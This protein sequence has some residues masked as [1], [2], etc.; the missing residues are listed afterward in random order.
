MTDLP[1]TDPRPVRSG[2]AGLLALLWLLAAALM[3]VSSPALI[4]LYDEALILT[5]ALRILAGETPGADFYVNYGPAQ[6]YA[7]AGVYRLFGT[8]MDAVRVYDAIV[9]GAVAPAVWWTL[10][11]MLPPEAPWRWA[12]CAATA[13]LATAMMIATRS[14]LYPLI[15]VTVLLVW[16]A[17][18]TARALEG[19][20]RPARYLPVIAVIGLASLVRYDFG[21]LASAAFAVPIALVHGLRWRGGRES[22]AVIGALAWRLASAYAVML[23]IVL[24]V[25]HA[26]G[27]LVPALADLAML[28]DGTYARTRA[29]PFPPV[30]F[31]ATAPVEASAIYLPFA[32]AIA[33]A[34]TLALIWRT[35]AAP[36]AGSG[37]VHAAHGAVTENLTENLTV[38]KTRPGTLP[39][40][41]RTGLLILLAVTLVGISKGMIRVSGI[42]FMAGSVPA[43]PLLALCLFAATRRREGAAGAPRRRNPVLAGAGLALAAALT[44]WT[45]AERFTG[46]A[47]IN[48]RLDPTPG[49]RPAIGHFLFED[50]WI[51]AAAYIAARTA[52]DERVHA[53]TGRH[54]KIFANNMTLYPLT[55][56]LPASRWHHYDP[57]VQTTE[58]VQRAMVA[59]L[60]RQSVRY[61]L[62]DATFDGSTEPNESALSSGITLFDTYLADT[63]RPVA[64]FGRF[65][66]LERAGAGS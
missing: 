28:A 13:A 20:Q 15:P 64:T 6:F 33:G 55:G 21:P 46:E 59:D 51:D 1:T 10:G 37:T 27:I 30:S 12:W 2:T 16:G 35:P 19:P 24:G 47:R 25:Q 22:T 66:V 23:S 45:A 42:Q 31:F 52:P 17:G 8:G 53:G 26:A 60:E 38:T 49:M 9:T 43:I 65:T 50:A 58:R 11:R 54:D 18:L 41:V 63:F 48:L 61:V 3:L 44:Y 34:T 4:N 14:P 57:G 36:D 62:S 32:A 40:T 39:E 29:L 7:V 56:R 5:G